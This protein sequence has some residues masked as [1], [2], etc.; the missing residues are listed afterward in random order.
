MIDEEWLKSIRIETFSKGKVI[1]LLGHGAEYIVFKVAFPD[2]RELAMRVKGNHLG[3][4]LKEIPPFMS[5]AP[6]YDVVRLN[7]KLATLVGN[8]LLDEM[9]DQYD[10]LYSLVQKLLYE[11]SINKFVFSTINTDA[12]TFILKSPGMTRRLQELAT[13]SIKKGNPFYR[14][15]V[16]NEYAFD[17]E[18]D[19]IRR[20]AKKALDDIQNLKPQNHPF[21][22]ET[23]AFNPLYA[24]GAAVMDGFFTDNEIPRAAD[25]MNMKFGP[26]TSNPA[27]S[28]Y[29]FQIGAI[30][31]LFGQFLP[32]SPVQ[33]LVIFCAKGG[34]LLQVVD[35]SGKVIADGFSVL[36]G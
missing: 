21:N 8:P 7:E 31:D 12:A 2:G 3:F 13:L 20:W 16:R 26:L 23:L 33:R 25:I 32:K 19:D 4:Y 35:G 1:G 34:F 36:K 6:L 18:T 17:V 14:V 15:N 27:A 24:W 29:S 11:T 10:L 5:P 30:A 22:P 9:T 28:V